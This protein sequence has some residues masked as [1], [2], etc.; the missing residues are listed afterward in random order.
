VGEQIDEIEDECADSFRSDGGA[1]V[2]LELV[3][4]G[5]GGDL[6]IPD[7]RL[8]AQL[9]EVRFQQLTLVRVE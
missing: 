9:L 6:L 5:G 2:T 3:G 8:A 1:E 7:R 4:V